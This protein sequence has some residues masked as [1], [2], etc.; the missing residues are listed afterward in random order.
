MAAFR[1]KSC[2]VEL[3]LAIIIRRS[4]G[5]S[6]DWPR[7][8]QKASTLQ[9]TFFLFFVHVYDDVALWG[10]TAIFVIEQ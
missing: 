3:E 9:W 7:D 4:T 1:V 10:S 6:R 2:G 5:R 8:T